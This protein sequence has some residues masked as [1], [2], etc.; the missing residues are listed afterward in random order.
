MAANIHVCSF[1]IYSF[2]GSFHLIEKTRSRAAKA[3]FAYGA[4]YR[5]ARKS[6]I[7]AQKCLLDRAKI[8]LEISVRPTLHSHYAR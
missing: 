2:V 4:Q 1:F 3:K 8:S 5:D 6:R 7:E